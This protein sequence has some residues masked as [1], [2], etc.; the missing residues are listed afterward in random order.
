MTAAEPPFRGIPG[1]QSDGERAAY[2]EITAALLNSPVPEAERIAQLGLYLD[3]SAL[4]HILFLQDLYRRILSVHGVI[5]EFGVRWGRNVALFAELRNIYEPRNFLRR[6]VGFD[7]FQGFPGVS[8]EDGSAPGATTGAYS[9]RPGYE[10][11]LSRLL[12]AHEYFGLRPHLHRNDV[13]KGDLSQT[14]PAY[15]KLHPETIVALAYFDLDLFEGTVRGLELIGDRLVRGS[16][17]A[18]DELC[19]Q[20]FPGET[21]ALLQTW[22]LRQLRLQ[23]SPASQYESFVVID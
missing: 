9:V 21:Q 10:E 5:L 13:V 2:A 6:I 20:Q 12:A 8:T 18:F 1:S 15:L 14:L 16:V 7:T 17:V 4:S 19:M 23:R 22:G 11:E 3:R